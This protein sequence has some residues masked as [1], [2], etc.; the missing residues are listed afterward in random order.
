ML[1][2]VLDP[3]FSRLVLSIPTQG[4]F[5]RVK[6]RKLWVM[7]LG[8]ELEWCTRIKEKG[9]TG[10]RTWLSHCSTCLSSVSIQSPEV[11]WKAC[12]YNPSDHEMGSKDRQIPG[13]SQIASSSC[14]RQKWDSVLNKEKKVPG[15]WHLELSR[16]THA[17][18]CLLTS[19]QIYTHEWG[20]ADRWIDR[21]TEGRT[22]ADTHTHR[23]WF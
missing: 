5:Q 12:S 8:S 14:S 4:C 9:Y 15:A 20:W 16:T 2:L 17:Y 1:S 22:G 11:R 3:I 19:A 7:D 13:L 23:K 21:W 18:I 10:M 6:R